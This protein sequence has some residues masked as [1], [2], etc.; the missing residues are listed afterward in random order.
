[1]FYDLCTY[2]YLWYVNLVQKASNALQLLMMLN[3]AHLSDRSDTFICAPYL[4]FCVILSCI[5]QCQTIVKSTM[6]VEAGYHQAA[7]CGLYVLCV[8]IDA[9]TDSSYGNYCTPFKC[10][11]VVLIYCIIFGRIIAE[12]SVV[13]SCQ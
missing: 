11:M 4:L 8:V 10:D 7:V 2:V 6:F 9:Y 5:C 1:M 3:S 12:L 13:P